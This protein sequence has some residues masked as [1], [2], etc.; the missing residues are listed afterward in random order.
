MTDQTSFIRQC[1][2]KWLPVS[3]VGKDA[4]L[5]CRWMY[6]GDVPYSYP[7]FDEA[8]PRFLSLPPNSQRKKILS[9]VSMLTEWAQYLDA[10]SPS[11]IIFHVSRCGSTLVSQ[12]LGLLDGAISIS[13][14]P[15]F[16][17]ILRLP[18]A[19][20]LEDTQTVA[21][22]LQS[23]VSFYGARRF[24]NERHL[25][26]KADSWHLLFYRQFRAL[27]PAVPFVIVYRSPG[28]V[29]E[30]NQRKKG[31]QGLPGMVEPALYSFTSEQKLSFHHPD[32]YMKVV[33]QKFYEQIIDI[34]DA[35]QDVLLLNYGC[36]P[37]QMMNDLL[38]FVD[39]SISPA[40]KARIADRCSYDAKHP[41]Q[42]FTEK[43]KA[44]H[45]LDTELLLDLYHRI[46]RLPHNRSPLKLAT[47]EQ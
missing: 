44:P 37:Q 2:H 18:A 20:K 8:I 4:G 41:E 1:L 31:I 22:A 7:F 24:G 33:L 16:D 27:Y 11:A 43:N 30:S 15:L 38:Q 47:N 6:T 23:A 14:V 17:E 25:F 36:G 5:S 13:E 9:S 39:I 28:E 42:S 46:E 3:L 45:H 12:A 21:K 32:D 34:A 40:E 19:G 35:D 10:L 29:L 26:V